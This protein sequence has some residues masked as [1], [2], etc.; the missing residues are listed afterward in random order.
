MYN[1]VH[2]IGKSQPGGDSG[3]LLRF[4]NIDMPSFEI[5]LAIPPTA[6]GIK[7]N[8]I[9]VLY[10]IFNQSP[11]PKYI[12]KKFILLHK[13][14]NINNFALTWQT[15]ITNKLVGGNYSWLTKTL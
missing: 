7:I 1:T 11:H 13:L 10:L 4:E 14:K 12:Y 3:G 9:R 15:I 2:T 8:K 5:K 6:K